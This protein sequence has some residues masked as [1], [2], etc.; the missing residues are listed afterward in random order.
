MI[1]FW[2]KLLREGEQKKD[3]PSHEEAT[4]F[5]H[6]AYRARQRLRKRGRTEFDD[7]MLSVRGA[8]LYAVRKTPALEGWT[9]LEGKEL[10]P[11][12]DN[13]LL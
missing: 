13:P 2:E 8:T 3:F 4:S 11:D 5:R 7:W 6:Q 12:W 9:N 10:K 1:Q